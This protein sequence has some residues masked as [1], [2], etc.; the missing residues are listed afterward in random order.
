MGENIEKIKTKYIRA[1]NAIN[2]VA[3]Y[4]IIST[5]IFFVFERYSI[6][7]ILELGRWSNYLGLYINSNVISYLGTSISLLINISIGVGCYLLARKAKQGDIRFYIA[8]IVIYVIDSLLS[9][10]N[11][12]IYSFLI[13]LIVLGY[14]VY[15][16]YSYTKLV[17][18]Y[19][20]YRKNKDKKE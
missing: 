12:D 8:F 17:V 16:H 11:F 18:E 10:F 7:Q 5:F 4:L 13:H 15:G 14:L 6:P 19:E 2:I 3:I 20:K 1:V 9:I